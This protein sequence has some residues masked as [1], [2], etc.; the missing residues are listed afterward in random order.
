M[1]LG[2]LLFPITVSGQSKVFQLSKP[3]PSGKQKLGSSAPASSGRTS[4]FDPFFQPAQAELLPEQL[5]GPPTIST[6]PSSKIPVPPPPQPNGTDNSLKIPLKTGPASNDVELQ[7]RNGKVTLI[8]HETP[9]T[10]VLALISQQSGLNLVA[11][12]DVVGNISVTL[13]D[14]SID[15]ALNALLRVNG[16][17]WNRQED[18]ILVTSLSKESTSLPSAQGTVLQV[19]TLDFVSAADLQTV[20]QS[21]LSPVG[22]VSVIETSATDQRR[23]QEQ[24]IVEDLPD[25]VAKISQYVCQVD[26]APRQVLVEAH[27]LQIDLKDDNRHGVNIEA[28]LARIGNTRVGLETTGFANPNES[29]AFFLSVDATDLGLLIEALQSTTDSKTL[30]SPKVMVLNGQEARLQIG[31][32]LGFLVTTTTQTSTLQQVDFL[33]TGVVLSVT[34]QITQDNR[35]LLNVKPEVS[36]GEI[37]PATGL[38]EEET[39]EVQTSVMLSDGQGMIIGGLI[40]EKDI[41]TQTKV[42][43]LGDIRKVGRL[44]QRRSKMR[45]RSEI[46]IALVPRLV[47]V[48]PVYQHTLDQELVRSTSPLLGPH[49]ESI[50]RTPLE[51]ELPDAMLNPRQLF[52]KPGAP[53]KPLPRSLRTRFP[54]VWGDENLRGFQ[55]RDPTVY[56]GSGQELSSQPFAAPSG[57]SR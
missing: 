11:A 14:V 38:P 41:E 23:T 46:V 32:Q 35:V 55:P 3:L 31:A 33:D 4:H 54:P 24:L 17:T 36:T 19:Y 7:I 57:R 10:T 45:Q 28:L 12:E 1:V 30:A 22:S 18:I 56:S 13:N 37:N 26:V 40:Q 5:V 44:F 48:N 47:P 20:V 25:Y 43:I 2:L 49:L 27:I 29:P 50:D 53:P 39:T 21:L 51:P 16:Y 52:R 15:A 42:P 9:I 6:E 34:P 8:A